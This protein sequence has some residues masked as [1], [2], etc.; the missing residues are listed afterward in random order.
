MNTYLKHKPSRKWAWRSPG[1]RTRQM[2]DYILI[3]RR[4]RSCISN[5]RS[6]PSAIVPNVKN[7]HNLV[8]AN[9]KV[10]IKKLRIPEGKERHE[11]QIKNRF[12]ALNSMIEE[13]S[14]D[15]ALD[16]VNRT[17]RKTAEEVIG[18]KRYRR[19]PWISDKVPNLADQRR[20]IKEKTSI[21]PQDEDL[22]QKNTHMKNV[23]NIKVE[24]FRNEW[25]KKQC[26]DAE[27]ASR[28]NDMRFRFQKVKTL[29]KGIELNYKCGSIR[30]KD[31]NLL[32]KESDIL[33]R[34]HEY[35]TS[36]YNA[37]IVKD[38]RVLELLWPNCKRNEQEPDLLE[39]EVR[40]VI[41]NIK[42]SKTPA[43]DGIERKLLKEG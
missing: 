28:K 20:T 11:I 12:E 5:A 1:D 15:E 29:K 31:G 18:F 3:D 37:K 16:N 32:T 22:K 39:N 23:I 7:D 27:E 36:L 14:L 35:G 4:W 19:E 6:Y 9:F 38:E 21:N 41:A 30:G 17:I 34:W 24:E 25:N 43:I 42:L 33:Q 40:A 10:D 26:Y 2:I 8:F 13:A